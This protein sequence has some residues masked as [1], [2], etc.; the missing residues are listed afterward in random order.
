[1]T[2]LL[3]DDFAFGDFVLWVIYFFSVMLF[4]WMLFVVLTDLFS[5][6]DIH[7]W[8]KAAWTIFVIVLP[9]IGILVYIATQGHSMAERAQRAQQARLEEVRHAVGYS[10]A[11][12]LEKLQRLHSAGTLTDDEYQ[13]AKA[14]I[15][16]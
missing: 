3:A 2:A 16:G 8:G 1:M 10:G 15:I 13:R 9:F 11:D 12:E 7:G 14:R 5:R 4:F 6:H